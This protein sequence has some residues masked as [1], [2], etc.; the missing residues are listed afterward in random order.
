MHS[1]LRPTSGKTIKDDTKKIYIKYTIADSQNKFIVIAATPEDAEHQI[2]KMK[3]PGN[4]VQPFLVI[5][6][7]LEHPKQTLV[8]FDSIKYRFHNILKAVDCC[9]QFFFVF[10][11]KYP[12]LCQIFWQFIQKH[13]YGINT[14]FDNL[15]PNLEALLKIFKRNS[16]K[17]N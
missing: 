14:E 4:P 2:Q 5:V 12:P 9:F 17:N 11:L 1:L 10:N 13:F 15:Y 8:Y 6:G 16:L 3:I 7:S